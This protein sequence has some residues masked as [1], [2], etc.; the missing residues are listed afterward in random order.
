[1]RCKDVNVGN[2]GIVSGEE[3]FRVV[4][5]VGRMLICF[6]CPLRIAK[7]PSTCVDA[8]RVAHKYL[9]EAMSLELLFALRDHSHSV[10]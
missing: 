2:R 6:A 10:C 9:S 7:L 1:M 5:G 3:T 8:H 4:A